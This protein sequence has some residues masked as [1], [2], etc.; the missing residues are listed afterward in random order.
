MNWV[1]AFNYHLYRIKTFQNRFSRVS[2][3]CY[4]NCPTNVLYSLFGVLKLD[5]MIDMEHAK[6]LYRF[7]NKGDTKPQADASRLLRADSEWT[8]NSARI[9]I[10]CKRI[11]LHFSK[12]KRIRC[13][14][15]KSKF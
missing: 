15:L 6:F 5:G 13:N 9:L 11:R 14:V 7:N 3:F 8:E 10:N 12:L 1:R 2:L 4:S